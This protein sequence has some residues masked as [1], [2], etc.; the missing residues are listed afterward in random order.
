MN[1]KAVIP[2]VAGLCIGGFALK[3]GFDTL[4]R[5]KGA[6]QVQT[7]PI[8][9]AERDIPRGTRITEDL[10]KATNFPTKF[11]PQGAITDKAKLLNRV[12]RIDSPGGLPILDSLLAPEGTMPGLTVPAGFRAVAVK[13]DESSGVDNH[14]LPGARV[15]VIGYFTDNRSGRQVTIARTL[16]E[17][18]Q[19]GA[20]GARISAVSDEKDDGSKKATKSDMK[21]ARAVVLFVKPE[22][23]PGLHLAEQRGKLKL[24]LRNDEDQAGAY[25]SKV[26][27]DRDVLGSEFAP[28]NKDKAP[29]KSIQ[30]QFA[31]LWAAKTKEEGSKKP[32]AAQVAAAPLPPVGWPVVVHLGA[33]QK[34]VRFKDE[35]SR[36]QLSEQV[37]PGRGNP[38]PELIQSPAALDSNSRSQANSSGSNPTPTSPPAGSGSPKTPTPAPTPAPEAGHEPQ[39]SPDADDA[40]NNTDETTEDSDTLPQE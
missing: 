33:K 18:V 17:N 29:Q 3:M 35:F 8:W 20:I 11:V 13:I 25:A 9:T 26:T 32:A 22:D 40:A 21:P 16:I 5:A 2:L 28:D 19:V 30:E 12:T 36:D 23:V 1:G 27:Q 4:Q 10:L 39:P 31:A 6:Q 14:L 15:D 7:T 24:S 34:I 38:K 37:D